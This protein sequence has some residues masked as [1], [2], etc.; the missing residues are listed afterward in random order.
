M[1]L[2]DPVVLTAVARLVAEAPTPG[3][4]MSRQARVVGEAESS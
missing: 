4:A 3:D 2:T 1:L